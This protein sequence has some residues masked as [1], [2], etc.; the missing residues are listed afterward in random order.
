MKKICVFD[1]DGTLVNSIS[2][3]AAAVNA[4]LRRLGKQEHPLD[5][6]YQMVGDGMDLLCK[7]CLLYTS[8]AADE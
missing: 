6:Y 5:A 3:I 2:D 7:S 4:S 8:D 1:L